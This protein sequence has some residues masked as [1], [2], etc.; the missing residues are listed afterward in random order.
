MLERERCSN[1][2]LCIVACYMIIRLD[3]VAFLWINH[4]WMLLSRQQ[5][6]PLVLAQVPKLC[7]AALLSSIFP[8]G[9]PASRYQANVTGRRQGKHEIKWRLH[10]L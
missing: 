8:Q 6:K 9:E 4:V 3:N 1:N 10:T 5:A 2:M 7:K